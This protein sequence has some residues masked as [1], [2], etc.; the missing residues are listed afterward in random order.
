MW[1]AKDVNGLIAFFHAR[2]FYFA[3][4]ENTSEPCEIDSVWDFVSLF[5][6]CF[7]DLLKFCMFEFE[8]LWNLCAY[9]QAWSYSEDLL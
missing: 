3:M 6:K 5:L 9:Q 1:G 2:S 7:T 8:I 4:L